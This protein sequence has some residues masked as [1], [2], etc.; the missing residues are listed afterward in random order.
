V[1]GSLGVLTQSY[2]DTARFA[3]LILMRC[4]NE[5]SAAVLYSAFCKPKPRA[6]MEFA[7]NVLIWAACF[8]HK[9]VF[10]FTFLRSDLFCHHME[11]TLA[12][13]RSLNVSKSDTAT[14][15]SH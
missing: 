6:L 15:V 3:K 4:L 8:R 11:S 10:R 13:Y 14:Q 2:M 7:K 9:T 1:R 12:T 5:V